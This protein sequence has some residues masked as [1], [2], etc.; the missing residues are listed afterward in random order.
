[1]DIK[2]NIKKARNDKGIS[3]YKLAEIMNNNDFKISQSAISKMENGNKK[4]DTDT[5]KAIAIA[6][7]T[8]PN[9]LMDSESE[10]T[11]AT[12]LSDLYYTGVMK[13]S[14]DRFFNDIETTCIREHFYDL[15]L[16]Y[17]ELIIGLSETKN[18]WNE[19]KESY[20]SIY[21]NRENPLPST[22]I[23]EMFLSQELERQINDLVNWV[24]AFPNWMIRRE[25]EL[26]NNKESNNEIKK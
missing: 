20:S 22:K 4:I 9:D 12:N 7:G 23:K 1:M 8:T 5:L 16:R 14:E 21:E 18:R 13:W 25:I 2:D 11:R 15:L 26:S 17:K 19:E 10:Y 6:L 3:T 24:E